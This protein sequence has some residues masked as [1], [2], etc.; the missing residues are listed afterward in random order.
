MA[1]TIRL[2]ATFGGGAILVSFAVLVVNQTAQV[3]QLG[4]DHP[5]HPGHGHPLG[6]RDDLCRRWSACRWSCS[7]G[8][9]AR[10]SPPASDD[11]PEFDLAPEEARR[12]AGVEPPPGGSRPRPIAGGSRRRCGSSTRRP[13]AIVREAASGVFLATAVSQSGRLDGL[14]VLAAQSRMVW[15]VAHLYHQRPTLRDIAH[16]YA[17]VAGTAFV[18]GELQEHRPRRA[19]RADPVV[20]ASAPWGE[21]AGVPGRRDD[22]GQLRARRQ[23]QRLPDPAGGHDRQAVLRRGGRPAEGVPAAGGDDRGGRAPRRD[24][25]RRQRP[26]LQGDV[27][28]VGGQGRRRGLGRLRLRQGRGR[29]DSRRRCGAGVPRGPDRQVDPG[30]TSPR[31]RPAPVMRRPGS[32]DPVATPPEG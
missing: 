17:N 21:P 4:D 31:R 12:A 13:T 9:P 25:R 14:L 22:P 19:G 11:G 18:A 30:L 7:S 8:C 27:A 28:G 29:R 6:P 32:P 1:R 10:S 23:R 20:G 15:R 2:L 16:L 3:V 24:R 5:P 26:A